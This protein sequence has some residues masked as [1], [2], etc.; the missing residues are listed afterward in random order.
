MKMDFTVVFEGMVEGMLNPAGKDAD[1]NFLRILLN[2]H[3][4]QEVRLVLGIGKD[5][6]NRRKKTPPEH[7]FVLNCQH[8]TAR[9]I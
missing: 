6:A 5:E 7:S 9:G 3:I 8:W 4:K 2:E 1:Y